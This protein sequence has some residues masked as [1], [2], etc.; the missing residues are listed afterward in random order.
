MPCN[1]RLWRLLFPLPNVLILCCPPLHRAPWIQSFIIR[2]CV[3]AV[4]KQKETGY[5]SFVLRVYAGIGFCAS[6]EKSHSIMFA[7][8]NL[9]CDESL[10][11]CLSQQWLVCRL[12]NE[13]REGNKSSSDGVFVTITRVCCRTMSLQLL[14]SFFVFFRPQTATTKMTFFYTACLKFQFFLRL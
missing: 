7:S 2:V 9:C 13:V 10:I 4:F 11:T 8:G 6:Q 3:I 12:L 14:K 1:A 5:V